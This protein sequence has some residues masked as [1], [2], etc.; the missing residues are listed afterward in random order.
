MLGDQQLLNRWVQFVSEAKEGCL[1]TAFQKLPLQIHLRYGLGA[2]FLPWAGVAAQAE[3]G[4]PPDERQ[5]T[6]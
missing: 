2:A 5:V 4:R 1:T 3:G 6:F